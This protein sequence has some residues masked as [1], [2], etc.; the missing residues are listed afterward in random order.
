MQAR[1]AVA[2]ETRVK[3]ARNTGRFHELA[4]ELREQPVD[5]RCRDADAHDHLVVAAADGDRRQCALGAQRDAEESPHKLLLPAHAV[6]DL[7]KVLELR[8]R[9]ALADK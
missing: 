5:L 3:A 7:P 9:F 4:R 6:G 8:L 2:L 1:R